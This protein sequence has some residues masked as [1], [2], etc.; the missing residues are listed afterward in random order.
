MP[1]AGVAEAGDPWDCSD[2]RY[3]HILVVKLGSGVGR[4]PLE[5]KSETV[6]T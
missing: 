5:Q 6:R 1:E 2:K 4:G 3:P